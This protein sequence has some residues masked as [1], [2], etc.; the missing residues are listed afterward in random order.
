MNTRFFWHARRG[1]GLVEYALIV[2]MIAIVCI[3]A[4]ASVSGTMGTNWS[5]ITTQ[6]G[7]AF[8]TGGP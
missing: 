8:G 7:V 3:A 4:M 5:K 1:Q 2:A 6:L